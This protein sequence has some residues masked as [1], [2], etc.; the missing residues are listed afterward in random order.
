MPVS[1]LTLL[2]I[3]SYFQGSTAKLQEIGSEQTMTPLGSEDADM[4]DR[5]LDDDG[6]G[7]DCDYSDKGD[8]VAGFQGDDGDGGYNKYDDYDDYNNYDDYNKHHDDGSDGNDG[9]G[10]TDGSDDDTGEAPRGSSSCTARGNYNAGTNKMA[11][12]GEQHRSHA[13][14]K[15]TRNVASI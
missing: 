15:W 8:S 6:D 12:E 10:R 3:K 1:D 5:E 2:I 7:G 4:H 14:H 11:S 13:P 9:G